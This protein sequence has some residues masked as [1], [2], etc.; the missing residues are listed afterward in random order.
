MAPTWTSLWYKYPFFSDFQFL[1][2]C[3]PETDTEE[4]LWVNNNYY[5]TFDDDDC[6]NDD[7]DF[8]EKCS[9]NVK[10]ATS[11]AISGTSTGS[12]TSSRSCGSTY[13]V[14]PNKCAK[15]QVLS[16]LS[17]YCH[18][19]VLNLD[20]LLGLSSQPFSST[21][22]TSGSTTS[23][24]KTQLSTTTPR[25][26]Q[27]RIKTTDLK[28]PHLLS[29]RSTPPPPEDFNFTK[30]RL[31]PENLAANSNSATPMLSPSGSSTSSTSTC[32]G[33]SGSTTGSTASKV[34]LRLHS[35]KMIG[36]KDLINS[37]KLNTNAIQLQLTALSQVNTSS[38]NEFGKLNSSFE[39]SEGGGRPKRSRRE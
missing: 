8:T 39:L 3:E 5:K 19:K 1:A 37:E 24:S 28:R 33:T 14:E 25:I 13:D 21:C 15:D 38:K 35:A 32:T 29:G 2:N 34:M 9:E 18:S 27:P 10:V 12:T 16:L 22:T 20:Y 17:E 6:D 30:K 36:L 7:D 23:G 4:L 26:T 31:Q 11:P